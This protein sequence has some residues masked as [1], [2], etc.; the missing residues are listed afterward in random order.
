MMLTGAQ[1]GTANRSPAPASQV[2]SPTRTV[3]QPSNTCQTAEPTVRTTPVVP[4]L[5]CR[6]AAFGLEGELLAQGGVGVLPAIGHQRAFRRFVPPP[7]MRA[8]DSL[9]LGAGT[10]SAGVR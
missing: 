5:G 8:E 3:P 7:F 1:D 4:R 2:W 10:D 9:G 6:P